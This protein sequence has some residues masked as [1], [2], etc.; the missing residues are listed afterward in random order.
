MALNQI[1]L[2]L[3]R[4]LLVAEEEE[5]ESSMASG[6][7]IHHEGDSEEVEEE[8]MK[9]SEEEDL[10]REPAVLK[11]VIRRLLYR[12]GLGRIQQ[13]KPQFLPLLRG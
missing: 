9:V 10:I 7:L 13:E 11:P 6:L 8:M 12:T 2:R 4:R 1:A 3:S 5:Q